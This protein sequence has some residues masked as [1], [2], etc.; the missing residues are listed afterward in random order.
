MEPFLKCLTAGLFMNVARKSVTVAPVSLSMMNKKKN[1]SNNNN[2]ENEK[3]SVFRGSGK[4]INDP[5]E[6]PYRTLR[7]GQPVHIHPSSVLF[8]APSGRKLPNYLVFAELLITSKHYMRNIT[9]IDESWLPE[10]V[11][12]IFKKAI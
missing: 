6:A 8:A 3:G 2:Q 10:L 9:V 7:G 4:E 11:P 12:T 5:D 1:F